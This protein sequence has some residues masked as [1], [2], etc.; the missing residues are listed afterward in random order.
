MSGF[1]VKLENGKFF[2]GDEKNTLLD[3]AKKQGIVLE[4]SCRTG[5]CGVCK[6]IVLEGSSIALKHEE[7]LSVDEVA[8]GMILS[9]CRA[10]ASDMLLRVEDLG[11][12]A[13][14]EIKTLPCRISEIVKLENSNVV[15]VFLRL[16]PAARFQYLAGQ[17]VDVIGKNG[18]R[19]SYSIANAPD[20]NNILELHVKYF[21]NGVMS[22]YWMH[23][24]MANDLLRLEGPLGTFCLRDSSV[25]HIV[26]LAT[27][28]G[29]APVKAMLAE[30]S[31]NF[32][33]YQEKRISVYWGGRC[34]NDIYWT[35]NFDHLDVDFY[36]VLSRM[37]DEWLG[38]RGYVQNALLADGLNLTDMIVY[39]CGSDSMIHSAKSL[40]VENGLSPMSFYSDAFVASN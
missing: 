39:A 20:E 30:M 34:L 2:N 16:P 38:K 40:L 37:G 24:A 32:D 31:L 7:S 17:Y 23:Q 19:R 3:E 5:R 25:N 10:A 14:I 11:R 12:L 36:P 22:E 4:H 27:G 13:E 28:T 26:F 18:V 33:K 9:C 1:L 15:K 21:P 6:T 29:I 35:P 8:Q